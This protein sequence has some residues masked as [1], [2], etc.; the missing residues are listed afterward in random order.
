MGRCFLIK[1][2]SKRERIWTAHCGSVAVKEVGGFFNGFSFTLNNQRFS[3]LLLFR[4][5]GEREGAVIPL[6]LLRGYTDPHA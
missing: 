5:L 6:N 1:R 4:E 3:P 2:N